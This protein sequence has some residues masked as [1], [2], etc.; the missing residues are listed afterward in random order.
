LAGFSIF[1]FRVVPPLQSIRQVAAG[2]AAQE[3]RAAATDLL[4]PHNKKNLHDLANCKEDTHMANTKKI[5]IATLLTILAIAATG[6]SDSNPVA[7]DTPLDTAPPA[8]VFAV[9]SNV[10]YNAG[11]ATISWAPNTVDTDLAG[12][13]VTRENKGSVVSLVA[14]PTMST[15]IAD[16]SP[17]PG[18]NLYSIYAVDLFGNES[19]VQ[20]VSVVLAQSHGEHVSSD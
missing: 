13:M 12:Y 4:R 18:I 17:R 15:Q 19:A 11:T 5:L 8:A 10:D 9:R 3:Q 14:T 20:R 1:C 7:L 16:L 2:G 6:C